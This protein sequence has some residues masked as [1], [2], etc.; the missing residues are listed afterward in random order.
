MLSHKQ[1][2]FLAT[3]LAVGSCYVPYALIHLL[4]LQFPI[5]WLASLIEFQPNP[6]AIAVLWAV[7]LSN[8]VVIV[9]ITVLAVRTITRRISVTR[10]CVIA[11][12]SFL[13]IFILSYLA[14]VITNVTLNL[15]WSI[16]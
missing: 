1:G 8:V 9:G 4:I 16:L 2:A 13:A 3:L 7:L 15:G 6:V 11:V 5:A 10:F 14:I 12:V